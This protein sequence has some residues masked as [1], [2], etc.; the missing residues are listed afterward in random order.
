MGCIAWLEIAGSG[1]IRAA[2]TGLFLG[3]YIRII[4][5]I[6][7]TSYPEKFSL[8]EDASSCIL[9]QLFFLIRRAERI[10]A[11]SHALNAIR[12]FACGTRSIHSRTGG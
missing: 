5:I 10:L 4:R 6:R 2:S 12:S 9:F 3:Y 7:T 11:R 8:L 1:G